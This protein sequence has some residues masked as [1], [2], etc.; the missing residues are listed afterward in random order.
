MYRSIIIILCIFLLPLLAY[1]QDQNIQRLFL[2]DGRALSGKVVIAENG[3]YQIETV[4]GDIFYFQ[5][6]EIDG[7]IGLHNDK[8]GKKKSFKTSDV[9][10]RKGN[11]LRFIVDNQPLSQHNFNT[12]TGWINYE[13]AKKNGK[14]GRICLYSGAG[15]LV[16]GYGTVGLLA[17]T[18]KIHSGTGSDLLLGL[19]SGVV[20]VGFITGITG[21][22][23]TLSSNSKLNK[24]ANTYNQNPGYALNFGVQQNGI[25]FAFNF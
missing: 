21:L 2:K 18:G 12:L 23:M 7:V 5:P 10:F 13:K 3:I 4:D 20:G 9:V 22:I 24:M 25:G 14:T 15:A 17:L 16:L 6:D 1:S 8:V 19:G 11:E